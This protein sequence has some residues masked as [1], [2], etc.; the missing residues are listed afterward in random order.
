MK[1]VFETMRWLALAAAGGAALA[2]GCGRATDDEREARNRHLRRA[3]AARDVQ[4]VDGAIVWCR[5]ALER[6]PDLALA[7][8]ELAIIYDN[9][10]EDYEYALYHYRRYLE[11][12]PHSAKRR[13]VEELIRRCRVNVAAQ[14]SESPVEWRQDLAARNA[15]IRSLELEVAALR[16]AAAPSAPAP[17]P[18]ARPAEAPRPRGPEPAAAAPAPGTRTHVVQA[19]ETLST[20]SSRY[21]GTPAKWNRILEANRDRLSSANNV[22]VGVALVIPQE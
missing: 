20:I 8:R 19:G 7:H 4:D 9:Y 11:L 22:R 5:R 13:E 6:R 3:Y 10:R 1:R 17:A 18:A 21:Y 14:V 15:R 2:A 12:R 16:Q